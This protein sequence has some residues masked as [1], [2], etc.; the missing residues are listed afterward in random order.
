ME[1]SLESLF[2]RTLP[3]CYFWVHYEISLKSQKLSRKFTEA[4]ARSC[5]VKIVFLKSF[6]K[7]TGKH[8]CHSIFFN[9]VAG[10]SPANYW[11]KDFG[12]SIFLWVLGNFC[13]CFWLYNFFIA[14]VCFILKLKQEVFTLTK[15]KRTITTFWGRT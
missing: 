14:T 2:Y 15:T 7:F 9:K 1:N 10:P 5:S 6:A 4:V 8:L 13:D 3:G 11:K 12:T